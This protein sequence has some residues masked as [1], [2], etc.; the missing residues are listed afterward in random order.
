MT[1]WSVNKTLKEIDRLRDRFEG[2]VL[3]NGCFDIYH[4]GH[5]K[6]FEWIQDKYPSYALVVALNSDKSIKALKGKHRP[7]NK[8]VD[9]FE[10]LWSVRGIDMFLV[11]DELTPLKLIKAVKPDI[12]VKSRDYKKADVVGKD[13]VES[14]GGKVV[15]APY[16]KGISTSEIIK[17]CRTL[18]S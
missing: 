2:I 12:L 7:I 8:L 9:R 15:L 1:F 5:A 13:F 10:V 6:T 17:K 14:Y 11:F 3:T 16:F 4:A 18:P